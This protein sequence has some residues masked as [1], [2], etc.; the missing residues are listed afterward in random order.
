MNISATNFS[1]GGDTDGLYTY[2]RDDAT[3]Q[4]QVD[5][6][7]TL[8]DGV[9]EDSSITFSDASANANVS[10]A[11]VNINVE[12]TP[13]QG[14]E[15]VIW[16]YP[17]DDITV[18]GWGYFEC[19]LS[20]YLGYFTLDR[21]LVFELDFIENSGD[22]VFA[23][24]SI[25]TGEYMNKVLPSF[26]EKYFPNGTMSLTEDTILECSLTQPDI[27]CIKQGGVKFFGNAVIVTGIY[28]K[29]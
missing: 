26:K 13:Q 11:T 20:D 16:E 1:Y 24:C 9:T 2:N 15:N 10:S 29:K 25:G 12:A 21:K 23:V 18:S 27:D 8:N 22:G 19:D 14:E 7:F 4:E 6:V 28:L 5:F 17:G 3:T